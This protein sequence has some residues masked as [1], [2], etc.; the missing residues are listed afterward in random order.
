MLKGIAIIGVFLDNWMGYMKSATTPALLYSLVKILALSVG[1]FVQVFFILSGFGLTL[2]YLKHGK[3]NWS[4]KRWAWRRITKIVVPYEIFAILSFILGIIGSHL[5]E[6]IDV[7]FS[8]SSLLAHLT[9]T[10]NFYPP[11]WIWNPSLWFMPVII[12]LYICF[13]ILLRILEKWGYWVLLLISVFVT[14]GTLIIATLTGAY[15]G[16][17][18]DWFSFWLV[19]FALGMVLAYV[20]ETSPQR[21]RLLLGSKAFILGVGLMMCSW[22]LRTYVPRGRVFNDSITSIGIFLVLL[23]LGWA[24]RA[25]VPAVGRVLNA[26][27]S[28]SYFMFL[29]HYPIMKFLIGPPLRIPTNPMVV[30][31]LGCVYI[32]VIFFLCYFI[33]KPVNKLTSRLYTLEA[34]VVSEVKVAL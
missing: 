7:Q 25:A 10:R 5:Y 21:L 26:L 32:P 2:A 30:L 20:R 3:T 12:G 23:N 31:I 29:I 27:S 9:F 28:Q 15:R 17:T 6:S 18:S 13:P 19:Q 34:H 24:I 1:P 22:A 16:H 11:S 14:Y 8:W 4:W 33:S